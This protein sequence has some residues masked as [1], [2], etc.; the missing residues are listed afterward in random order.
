M[1]LAVLDQEGMAM[2]LVWLVESSWLS[3]EASVLKVK[4]TYSFLTD[5]TLTICPLVSWG[6]LVIWVRR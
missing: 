2:M 6:N 5:L 4:G 3:L 1:T